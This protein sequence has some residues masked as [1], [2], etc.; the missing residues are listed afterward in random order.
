MG[1][2]PKRQL[3]K[4]CLTSC[5]LLLSFCIHGTA[6]G[7]TFNFKSSEA[8]GILSANQLHLPA[9]PDTIIVWCNEWNTIL[10][11]P[12]TW[13]NFLKFK[14]KNA[15]VKF[16]IDNF[17]PKSQLPY[18]YQMTYTLYGYY[19]NP[20]VDSISYNTFSDT[21]TI[22]NFNHDDPHNA[23]QDIQMAHFGNFYKTMLVITGIY[24]YNSGS[25]IP[26]V[27]SDSTRWNF[28]I[29]SSIVTQ[30]YDKTN[31]GAG[32]SLEIITTPDPANNVLD[33]AFKLPGGSTPVLLTPVNY[34][35]EWTYVDDYQ[36]NLSSGAVSHSSPGSLRYD[37]TNN[38]TRVWLDSGHYR[39]PLV[40]PEGYLV[41]RVR[42]VRPDSVSFRY[43][44]Y[45]DWSYSLANTGIISGAHSGAV[46]HITDAYSHDS[47]NWQYTVSFAEGGKY[48][49]VVSFFDGLLKN[50]ESITRFNSNL[51]K[52]IVTKNIYDFEGRPSIKTLPA[53]V[54]SSSFSF[55]HN[56][57]L[58]SVTGMPYCANDFDTG[59][60]ICPGEP[61][62]APL[63][64]LAL[65][66]IYYSNQNPDTSGYQKFVPDAEGYPLVQTIYSPAF[67]DRIDKQG[68]AGARLQIADSNI[69][70]N[71]YV[72]TQQP[73]INTL[74]GLDIG[75]N[76]YYNMTVTKDPNMQLSLAIKDY[77]GRQVATA[78]VGTGPSPLD[79]AIEPINAPGPSHY[80]E[81]ILSKS[82]QQI[83]GNKRIADRD[84]FNQV[85]GNDSIQY[86]Y[87]FSPYPV[88]PGQYL[89]VKAHYY[90]EVTDQCGD[91]VFSQ[92]STLGITGVISHPVTFSG[93]VGLM[94]M[95][96][97]KYS[98]HK[99]L[100]INPE[101]V[102]EAI[103]AWINGPN[104]LKKEPWFIRRSIE[105]R[106]FPCPEASKDP[107]VLKKQQMIYD[108]YPGGT[109]AGYTDSSG[110]IRG[111]ENGSIFD[112]NPC[113][114]CPGHY[115]FQD[116]CIMQ[117]IPDTM[118][119]G[120][121]PYFHLH[122]MS[123]DSFI[124][125]YK[126][127]VAAGDNRIAEA[128]LPL[129][130][131]FC[132]GCLYD[133]F[134][135]MLLAIP[136]AKTAERM[137]VLYLDSIV[138]HDPM[139]SKIPGSGADSLATFPGGGTGLV[140]FVLLKAYCGCCYSVML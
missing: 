102:E 33:V 17:Y 5:L 56:V 28:N 125:V 97:S 64:S 77:E 109:Y 57:D 136:N 79:H 22:S 72:T 59:F 29:E 134:K 115:T 43:P 2:Y 60:R 89:S 95:E 131:E 21:L 94:H 51:N 139:R 80:Q 40:Y 103:Y 66:S 82:Y 50:R 30:K 62:L 67:N 49:H 1:N 68:G 54:S 8:S 85:S 90:Y 112:W 122:T 137:N 96:A 45:S 75:W 13:N 132:R 15:F 76:N 18:T 88:C 34:E 53:P 140:Y 99:E 23:Y 47:L 44:I 138:A 114:E 84:F 19:K 129:H 58:N 128:L 121:I 14:S 39:I 78:M 100:S 31:Y 61:V 113:D 9:R 36:R 25:P 86:F 127:S 116:S 98:V 117:H 37:F 52:L 71:F 108:L 101:D 106:K 93:S 92:D 24:N 81:D 7:Q 83:S 120:G 26:A 110:I 74:F 123:V 55:R 48:K 105:K 11:N 35:L 130:P 119:I 69:I 38:N 16:S 118:V 135:T 63:G 126:L 87:Q 91:T 12:T 42:M 46:Y 41:Y 3:S 124:M 6:N 4:W 70:T 133:T 73:V 32:T 27:L 20:A 10:S 104:C 111:T 65:A 107:C